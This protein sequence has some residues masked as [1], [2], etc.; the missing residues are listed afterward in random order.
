MKKVRKLIEE[1][2]LLRKLGFYITLDILPSDGSL[3]KLREFYAQLIKSENNY[4][5]FLR[6]KS[7]LLEKGFIKIDA[8]RIY[9]KHT[10]FIRLTANGV[11]LKF[12]LKELIKQIEKGD[13]K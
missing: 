7:E 12:R 2:H 6:V 1:G 3:I 10:R 9:Q 4:N 5:T 13:D 8:K 11:I